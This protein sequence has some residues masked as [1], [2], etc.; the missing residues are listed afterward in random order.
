M[1]RSM[2]RW[3]RMVR[4]SALCCLALLV[5]TVSGTLG[6]ADEAVSAEAV[7]AEAVRLQRQYQDQMLPFLKTHCLGCH[8]ADKQEGQLDLSGFASA[9]D[10]VQRF[11][12]WELVRERL[13]A[14]EMP[15]ESV[16][17]R[18]AAAETQRTL[19]WIT[20]LRQHE[21]QRNAGDPGLVPARRLS[22]AEFDYSIRD[23]TGVDIRPT[24]EFPVDPAN[25]AG[26]DNSGESLT[27]S[28]ALA[29]K[30]LEAVRR[31]A[32]HLVLQPEGLLFAP[33]PVVTDT[34]RDRFCVQR[35]VDFYRR[36][37]VEYEKYFLAAWMYQHRARLGRPDAR[38]RD[39]LVLPEAA[40]QTPRVPGTAGAEIRH[41]Q[42]LSEKYLRQI[43]EVLNNETE[44][45]PLA[46]IRA[47]W[48]QLPAEPD[49][50]TE[51]W[52]G[53][54]SLSDRVWEL[55]DELTPV[56]E[57]L[58][59]D[60][61]SQGSQ[62]LVLWWNGQ[63]SSQRLG[64][65]GERTEPRLDDARDRFC[66][67]FPSAFSVSSRGHYANPELGSGVR[68]LTAG[69][70]LMHGYFRDDR[71]LYELIL[72]PE[73][74]QELDALW[75]DLNFV[76]QSPI[77]Q[78]KDFLFFE[79]A[80]P[81]RF[82]GG[83]EFDFARPE[84]KDVTSSDKLQ[85]M[86]DVCLQ[87]ARKQGASEVA[88]GAI[89]SYFRS[90]DAEIRWIE[91]AQQ[92]A[93]PVHLHALLRLAERAWRRPLLK[94]EQNDLTAFYHELRNG[95]GLSHE[96]AVRDTV[97]SILMS[98][99]FCYRFD[100]VVDGEGIQPLSDYEL[101]SRLSYF[102]WCSM[103]D[104]QLLTAAAAGNLR[105]RD[106]LR[107]QTRRM[108][109][110]DRV[111]GLAVEF[112]GQWL[113]MRR[114]EE[115]NSVDRERFPAFTN[116]LRASMYEEPVRFLTSLMRQNGSL[117]DCLEADYTFVNPVLAQ[118]YGMTDAWAQITGAA[119]SDSGRTAEPWVRIDGAGQYGRGGLLPMAVFL[120]KNSPGLRT[121]PVKRGY[122]VVR[123]LLGEHIPAPPPSVPELPKDEAAFGE[124]TLA[125]LL[126]RHRDHAACAGCHE[127]FDAVGLVFEGYGPVGETRVTDL[128][129]RSVETTAT[130]P[131]Q[132]TGSGI[133]GLRQY[134]KNSRQPDF[135]DNFC[136]KLLSFALGRSLLLSDESTV[137]AMKR[138][139]QD[140]EYRVHGLIEAI[141]TS[142]QF[143]NKREFPK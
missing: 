7:S 80:E 126:A 12:V 134:L 86:H 66:R 5:V 82:A 68:L 6:R 71:P 123:R 142:P 34:D 15:P 89:S 111:R 18:P 64:Y 13:A 104:E 54:L 38:L 83:P 2:L 8:G 139:L 62:P 70:H 125:Q 100:V 95:D 93:E 25:E 141:V 24:R 37:D 29:K 81:P 39:F 101:A 124:M 20:A 40:D 84:N 59:V 9:D 28:P 69:F 79:R 10:V 67:L 130:F 45:G 58:Q 32:D 53:C 113:D 115:H 143:L 19:D 43:V 129:G 23:L 41:P 75:R 140:N 96:E 74:Q 63:K 109:E 87:K 103:P 1:N 31:V 77:R 57:K 36:H 4:A 72:N 88:Q 102:L 11:A 112:G 92:K 42:P 137:L 117:L 22:N 114:F 56:V 99:Y 133:E 21:A 90:M 76:T 27:M 135:V 78:Y 116:E 108:L 132:S 3:R 48:Q 98:P 50:L 131:D 97:A 51:V 33:Y 122:W 55:R 44:I 61:M 17:E 138:S 16:R 107:H 120:T 49:R 60:G 14:G 121:S 119:V 65:F 106:V 85:Q 47:A 118:H 110:D 128:G 26:F 91:Q 52:E 46:E 73:Q 136:R 35:I 30:Y 127:R 105:D 94:A